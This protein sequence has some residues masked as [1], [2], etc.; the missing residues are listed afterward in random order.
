MAFKFELVLQDGTPVSTFETAVPN[1]SP[2]HLVLLKPDEE[3]RVI[4]VREGVLVV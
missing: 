3:Y 4:E 1:W 2:G